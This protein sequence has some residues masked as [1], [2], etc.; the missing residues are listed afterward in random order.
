MAYS[1]VGNDL[2]KQGDFL[3]T[4]LCIQINIGCSNEN[5]LR[6]YTR[7]PSY[8]H[9]LSHHHIPQILLYFESPLLNL[10]LDVSRCHFVYS[11]M[12]LHTVPKHNGAENLHDGKFAIGVVFR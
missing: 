10:D 6:D 1:G 5:P 2:G 11:M 8:A 12:L 4:D 9:E 7:V 3:A